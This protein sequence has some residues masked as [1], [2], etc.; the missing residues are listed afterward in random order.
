[1]KGWKE[2]ITDLKESLQCKENILDD[3]VKKLLNKFE[4]IQE[5]KKKKNEFLPDADYINKKLT[6]LENWDK[7]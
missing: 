4:S 2:E 7:W 5:N 6:E 1:M 3:R